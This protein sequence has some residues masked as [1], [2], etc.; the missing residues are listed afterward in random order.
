MIYEKKDRDNQIAKMEAVSNAFY[1]AAS[2][3][4]VHAFIEFCGLMNE[5]IKMCQETSEAGKD[6][7]ESNTHTGVEL[8]V[9]HHHLEY[10]AEKFDCIF[11]TTLAKEENREVFF[12]AMEWPFVNGEPSGRRKEVIEQLCKMMGRVWQ[13][14]DPNGHSATDCVCKPKD[15]YRNEGVALELME[16]AVSA[17]VGAF[18]NPKNTEEHRG[19]RVASA[20]DEE[21][22][23]RLIDDEAVIK[24]LR[25]HLANWFQ[26]HAEAAIVRSTARDRKKLVGVAIR[27]TEDRIWSLP[28]PLR[29]MHVQE[30]MRMHGA[31]QKPDNHWNQGFI[32]E[33]GKYLT[34]KQA[35]VNAEIHNQIKGGKLIN[36]AVLTSE[37]LW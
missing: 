5:F 11:G 35:M 27:D 12:K 4:G 14:V 1:G 28:A 26:K 29:H 30:V 33:D 37:D 22:L 34:R 16:E 36:P 15:D 18:Q 23:R 20:F 7:N 25:T 21:H 2:Q 24:E 31:V 32:D 8:V 3:T 10:L 17:L 6:F 9:R 19:A 13:A